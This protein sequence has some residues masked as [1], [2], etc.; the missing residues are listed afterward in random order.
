MVFIIWIF[1]KLSN[2]GKIQAPIFLNLTVNR[3]DGLLPQESPCGR[4]ETE[5]RES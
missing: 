5:N 2:G 1:R 4:N 3:G